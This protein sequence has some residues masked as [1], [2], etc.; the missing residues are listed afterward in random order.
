MEFFLRLWLSIIPRIWLRARYISWIPIFAAIA[1]GYFFEITWKQK[2]VS[3][4]VGF[5]LSWV[6]AGVVAFFYLKSCNGRGC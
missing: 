4:I 5:A 1:W 3:L 6:M 2:I